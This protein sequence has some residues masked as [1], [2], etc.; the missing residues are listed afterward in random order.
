[1]KNLLP[2]NQQFD[3]LI[4]LAHEMDAEGICDEETQKRLDKAADLFLTHDAQAIIL[5][6]WAYLSDT[7]CTLSE[8]MANY[9]QKQHA[10]SQ[11]YLHLDND[12]RDT[13]GDAYFS[14][15]KFYHLM[16]NHK[17]CVVTSDYHLERAKII[18]EFVYGDDFCCDFVGTCSEKAKTQQRKEQESIKQFQKTFENLPIGDNAAIFERMRT[19]HSCYNGVKYPKIT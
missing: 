13:V 3:A 16:K 10:I 9:L 5:M 1:M 7:E 15:V 18:F 8:S 12:S 11:K 2:P 6:G 4:V 19:A 17:I 14:K